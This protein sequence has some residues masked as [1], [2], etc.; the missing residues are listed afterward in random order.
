MGAADSLSNDNYGQNDQIAQNGQAETS[1]GIAAA[2]GAGATAINNNAYPSSGTAKT[3]GIGGALGSGPTDTT[4]GLGSNNVNTE[5]TNGTGATT[6]IN[7]TTGAG[8]TT[9]S[10]IGGK[11]R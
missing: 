9:G 8:T 7:A 11:I 10:S 3:G 4:S 1:R 6:G 2:S 5:Y